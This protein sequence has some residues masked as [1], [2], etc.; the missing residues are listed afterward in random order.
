M[1]IGTS[2]KDKRLWTASMGWPIC[3]IKRGVTAIT[4]RAHPAWTIAKVTR[5]LRPAAD[6]RWWI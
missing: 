1:P 2:D 6:F 3:N 5:S 4:K